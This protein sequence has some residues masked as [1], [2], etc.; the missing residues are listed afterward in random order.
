MSDYDGKFNCARASNKVGAALHWRRRN[1]YGSN[2]FYRGNVVRIGCNQRG[3]VMP[4]RKYIK[5]GDTIVPNKGG[6]GSHLQPSYYTPE[7]SRNKYNPKELKTM[8]N[9]IKPADATPPT[10]E[11]GDQLELLGT[12]KDLN[13]IKKTKDG[14]VEIGVPVDQRRLVKK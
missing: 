2:T 7:I 6:K 3:S 5:I 4:K 11:E 9:K 8:A 14:G 1:R 12:G 13:F 10:V